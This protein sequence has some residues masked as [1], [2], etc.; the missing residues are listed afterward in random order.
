M[1]LRPGGGTVVVAAA[2]LALALAAAAFASSQPRLDEARPAGVSASATGA[3]RISDSRGEAAILRAPALAPGGIAVGGLT[4]SN[5]GPSARLV[6]SRTNLTE[7]PGP[8]G[9]S[10]TDGLRLRIR[11]VDGG[12]GRTVYAGPL[13]AMPTLRLGLLAAD[14]DRHYRFVAF[15]PE[16]G[17]LDNSL[18]GSRIRFDYRWRLTR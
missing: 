18:M 16:P 14:E 1:E 11:F 4:I 15:L 7:T 5:L 8:G 6:L 9:G 3:L 12:A 2:V 10:L 13:A 17:L